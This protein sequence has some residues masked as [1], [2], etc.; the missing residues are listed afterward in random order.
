MGGSIGN[1]WK[2]SSVAGW[3]YNKFV[4]NPKDEAM[5]KAEAAQATATEAKDA[6]AKNVA[7]QEAETKRI[8][9]VNLLAAGAPDSDLGKPKTGKNK[10]LG[11]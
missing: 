6:L 10:L 2:S 4:E 11:N 7:A 3:A 1:I 9:V 8:G 5:Q